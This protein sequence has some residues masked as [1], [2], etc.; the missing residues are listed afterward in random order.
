[1]WGVGGQRSRQL[2]GEGLVVGVPRARRPPVEAGGRSAATQDSNRRPVENGC[3][4]Q[5]DAWKSRCR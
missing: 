4:Q 2:S 1:M 3:P 5:P